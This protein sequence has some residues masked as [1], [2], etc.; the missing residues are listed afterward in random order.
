MVLMETIQ[1]AQVPLIQH[2]SRRRRQALL[3]CCLLACLLACLLLALSCLLLVARRCLLLAC[4]SRCAAC[5]ACAV[6]T[7]CCSPLLASLLPLLHA[8][9]RC[10]AAVDAVGGAV[11]FV[12]APESVDFFSPCLLSDPASAVALAHPTP[13]RSCTHALVHSCTALVH[14]C[15]ALHQFLSLGSLVFVRP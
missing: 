6:A 8:P 2:Q 13:A 14:S 12:G 7:T 11:V 9:A 3:A 1:Q 15:T 10:W 5:A 4:C